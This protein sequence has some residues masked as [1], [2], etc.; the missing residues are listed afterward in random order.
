MGIEIE[1]K[2]LVC[3]DDWKDSAEAGI[4]IKQGFF[5]TPSGLTVRARIKGDKAF[6]TIKGKPAGIARSEFEYPIPRADAEAMLQEFCGQRIIEKTR[7]CVPFAGRTFEVD[8]FS[9][10]HAGL[11]L[12]EVELASADD[13]PE[14]PPWIGK[15]ISCDFAY[16]NRALASH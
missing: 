13:V 3:S 7:Y 9:G 16:T 14:L 10:R 2:Y 8:V 4:F 1:Y 6:L 12:A 11:V 15:D 5:D